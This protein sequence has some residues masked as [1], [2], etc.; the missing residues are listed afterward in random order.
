MPRILHV[1]HGRT[2]WNNEG[3][4][5]GQSDI[6]L[7]EEG[8]EGAR[9]LAKKLESQH[10]TCAY[11]SD[12]I[13]ATETAQIILK[14]RNIPLNLDK[15]LREINQGV[16]EGML[17]DDIKAQYAKEMKTRKEDPL[18]VAPPEGESLGHFSERVLNT[19]Q[20]IATSH[21]DSDSILV[22]SHGLT[23]A[24]CRITHL[25]IPIQEVY[26]YIPKNTEVI[27]IHM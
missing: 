18:S 4:Y 23:I 27:E 3:R 26:N 5:T 13:R 2:D 22:T 14:D 15:G 7:N 21:S 1:R 20:K 19:M 11:S 16:W 17:F 9:K 12:L 10:I 6:P 24:M 8:R 25:D